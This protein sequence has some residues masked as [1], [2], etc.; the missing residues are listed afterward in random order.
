[1]RKVLGSF[2]LDLIKQFLTESLILCLLALGIACL[3]LTML[4]PLFNSLTAKE[5]LLE[6]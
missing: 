3:L 2:R 1:L 5:L 6:L 4:L